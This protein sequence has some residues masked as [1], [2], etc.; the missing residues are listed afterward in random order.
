M[1]SLIFFSRWLT[2]MLLPDTRR[3]YKAWNHLNFSTHGFFDLWTNENLNHSPRR[4]QTQVVSGQILFHSSAGAEVFCFIPFAD[5]QIFPAFLFI[6]AKVRVTW[7]YGEVPVLSLHLVEAQSLVSCSPYRQLM[8]QTDF[9][10]FLLLLW[11]TGLLFWIQLPLWFVYCFSSVTSVVQSQ[12]PSS[13]FIQH[14]GV[15]WNWQIFQS[16]TSTANLT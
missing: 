4:E 3:Y 2:F 7:L 15:L 5:R 9:L 13:E 6:E 8:A 16:A 11:R 12:V 10:E 14:L 1:I